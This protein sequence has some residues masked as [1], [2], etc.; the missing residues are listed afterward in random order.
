VLGQLVPLVEHIARGVT[1]VA[2]AGGTGTLVVGG[3][4][5]WV[6]FLRGTV[7][8]PLCDLVR[9]PDPLRG[10][11][12]DVVK[13]S[14]D[15]VSPDPGCTSRLGFLHLVRTDM[16]R[17]LGLVVSEDRPL[18]V[19]VDDLD[20]C[21]SS[22]VAQVIRDSLAAGREPAGRHGLRSPTGQVGGL[23]PSR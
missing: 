19:F 10:A 18:I 2:L 21:S 11:A 16:G 6:S 17:V 12:S 22:T 20:R 23:R 9:E 8:G 15:R 7:T 5:R 3:A 1:V 13:D 14:F 4:I